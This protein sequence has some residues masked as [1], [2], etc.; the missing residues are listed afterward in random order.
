MKKLIVISLVVL[1][2]LGAVGIAFAWG[3]KCPIDGFRMYFT[4]QTRVEW[5]NIIW[6]YRC[7]VGHIFWTR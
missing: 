2:V 3:V 7:P 5:G 4:G 1:L 6:K